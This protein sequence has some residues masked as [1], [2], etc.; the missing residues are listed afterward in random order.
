MEDEGRQR[1]TKY[2]SKHF[3]EESK[4]NLQF[5]KELQRSQDLRGTHLA[6]PGSD[7]PAAAS[8]GRKTQTT[9]R[10]K[11][12]KLNFQKRDTPNKSE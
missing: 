9:T 7:P 4:L 1:T 6:D 2:I 5:T 12:S 11:Q 3:V 10:L 8:G